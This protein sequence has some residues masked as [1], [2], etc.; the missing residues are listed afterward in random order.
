[1]SRPDFAVPRRATQRDIPALARVINAAYKVE[2][3]FLN[4]P[5]TSEADLRAKLDSPASVFL[6]LDGREPGTLAGA[7]H[8]ELRGERGYFGL[9]SVD[10][11]RQGEGLARVLVEAAEAH[12][13]Q[14]GCVALDIDVVNLRTELPAFYARFGLLPV[15]TAP[16]PTHEKLKRPVHLIVMSKPLV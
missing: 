16:F 13:R 10:P 8:V 3:F 4:A 9:L 5:R 6:V 1:M 2:E 15:S 11:A 12:C 14:A 7:V